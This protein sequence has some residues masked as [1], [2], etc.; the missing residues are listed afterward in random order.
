MQVQSRNI[1]RIGG[2]QV[3][4][5]LPTD[6]AK[7]ENALAY[8]VSGQDVKESSRNLYSRTLKL[9]FEWT[10]GKGKQIQDLTRTD[11]L[12]IPEHSKGSKNA[13]QGTGF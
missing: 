6:G 13:S 12:A 1:V 2:A 7:W 9:F 4:A 10:E 3:V 11:I 8:F 5:S